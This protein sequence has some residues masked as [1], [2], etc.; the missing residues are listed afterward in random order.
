MG[1][2]RNLAKGS[3]ANYNLLMVDS[4]DR[5]QLVLRVWG[6]FIFGLLLF[7]IGAGVYDYVALGLVVTGPA[8]ML[9]GLLIALPFLVVASIGAYLLGSLVVRNPVWW[10]GA[11]SILAGTLSYLVLPKGMWIAVL[12]VSL[13]CSGTLCMWLGRRPLGAG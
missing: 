9:F 3:E 13:F 4:E 10:T 6:S 12:F 7:A 5:A 8:I 2:K 11:A 1:G